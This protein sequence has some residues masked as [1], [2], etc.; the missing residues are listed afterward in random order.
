MRPGWVHAAERYS[1]ISFGADLR[2]PPFVAR[3]LSVYPSHLDQPGSNPSQIPSV[4]EPP[5]SLREGYIDVFRGLLTA[6]MALD[7]ASLLFNSGRGGEEIWGRAPEF[8]PDLANFLVRFSGVMVAPAFVFMAGFMV[9]WTSIKREARGVSPR[10]VNRRL[11]IRGLV[12]IAADTF[13]GG[14]P[15]LAMGFYSF[16]VLSCIGVS[17]LLLVLVRHLRS[18][19]LLPLSLGIIFLHPLLDVSSLPLGLRLLL[20]EPVREGAFRSLYPLIPWVGVL[21]LGYIVGRDASSGASR[22][23]LWLGLA[24][25]SLLLFFL[26]RWAGYGSGFESHGIGTASFW[27]FSK[28]PP[29]LP[30]LTWAFFWIFLSLVALRRICQVEV[31]RVLRP[32]VTYGQVSFFF[33][34]VHFYLLG[35]ARGVLGKILGKDT[36]LPTTFVVWLV[37]LI[38][39]YWLCQ[40]YYGKKTTRPNFV[41]RYL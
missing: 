13:I 19:V 4:S 31:P 16:M 36:G 39:M 14:L 6:H 23:K 20:H 29:D 30:F 1:Y 26:V 37:L 38:V 27:Y 41:T 11:L 17:I 2:R 22:S 18:V 8:P 12:L 5:A 9:A 28:Y 35:P 15:R 33:Y 7:H 24:G 25:L 34:L 3:R 21:F 32:F 10:E 40:W